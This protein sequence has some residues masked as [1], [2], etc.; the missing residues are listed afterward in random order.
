MLRKN[1]LE[2]YKKNNIYKKLHQNC[3]AIKTEKIKPF[4]KKRRKR[5]VVSDLTFSSLF[6]S[7]SPAECSPENTKHLYQMTNKL[8][9]TH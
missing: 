9:N 2:M 5:V 6:S 3:E 8:T 1:V 7:D 4:E